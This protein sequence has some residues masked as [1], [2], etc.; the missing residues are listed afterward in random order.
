MD[1]I[2]GRYVPVS[3]SSTDAL[4][5]S[6]S[7]SPRLVFRAIIPGYIWEFVASIIVS[8]F[9]MLASVR[10]LPTDWATKSI[11][12]LLKPIT[13]FSIV[14]PFPIWATAPKI[15]TDLSWIGAGVCCE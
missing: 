10:I 6:I 2:S 9:L 3:S 15:N 11:V 12:P 14:W 5:A 1:R 7:T 8:Y 13:L 4:T